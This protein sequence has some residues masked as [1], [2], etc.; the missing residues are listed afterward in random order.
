MNIP[1][2]RGLTFL[3]KFTQLLNDYNKKNNI[4][5]VSLN[6]NTNEIINEVATTNIAI[7]KNII[8]TPII[9][10]CKDL[11]GG[12]SYSFNTN[13]RETIY[14]T[15]TLNNNDDYLCLKVNK[16]TIDSLEIIFAHEIFTDVKE[17]T[18]ND[19]IIKKAHFKKIKCDI[20]NAVLIKYRGEN[21]C[22]LKL[23][24]IDDNGFINDDDD[25]KITSDDKVNIITLKNDSKV[26]NENFKA[27]ILYKEELYYQLL[28]SKKSN[29]TLLLSFI[30]NE[31]LFK[32]IKLSSF[33]IDDTII[34]SYTFTHILTS[35]V[36]INLIFKNN[37]YAKNIC[38]YIMMDKFMMIPFCLS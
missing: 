10:K 20:I 25:F 32:K 15:P 17:T 21:I 35:K 28:A 14:Y 38:Y 3:D 13:E 31:S 37:N 24:Y 16:K 8:D 1:N 36:S 2:V 27:P 7:T 11:N 9:V 6:E 26:N 18:K 19:D 23:K 5:D 22:T 30:I 34:T 12:K 33:K 4:Q 29:D